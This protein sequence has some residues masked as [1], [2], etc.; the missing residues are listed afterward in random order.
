MQDILP[1]QL[2]PPM[3][4]DFSRY[5]SNHREY[6]A[7]EDLSP[8]PA[9][10][11]RPLF[12]LPPHSHH[13]VHHR[14]HLGARPKEV[15]RSPPSHTA[16]SGV[17]NQR[18]D[19]AAAAAAAAAVAAA[20]AARAEVAARSRMAAVDREQRMEIVSDHAVTSTSSRP[21]NEHARTEPEDS[22]AHVAPA[23]RGGGS[24]KDLKELLPRVISNV[25]DK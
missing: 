18:A 19:T 1:S 8:P 17:L 6:A 20:A 22:I 9:P 21:N 2:Q 16:T 23:R 13:V 24:G 4:F 5:R 3:A 15:P 12:H 11:P 25:T 14:P 7:A 10:M